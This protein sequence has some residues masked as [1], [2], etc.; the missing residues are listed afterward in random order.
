[1]RT[2]RV[3][4]AVFSM[5]QGTHG[6]RPSAP[7]PD[8]LSRVSGGTAIPYHNKADRLPEVRSVYGAMQIG[9][10]SDR[11][12]RHQHRTRCYWNQERWRYRNYRHLVHRSRTQRRRGLKPF[13]KTKPKKYQKLEQTSKPENAVVTKSSPRSL[14]G[15]TSQTSVDEKSEIQPDAP[16]SYYAEVA[17]APGITSKNC[18]KLIT[19]R[20][21][22]KRK[23]R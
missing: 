9:R 1:M 12:I 7:G 11:A 2:H 14:K 23:R 19:E 5:E 22:V 8:V 18:Q 16:S 15:N 17:S 13:C 10:M 3:P 4:E 21:T 6:A 20:A